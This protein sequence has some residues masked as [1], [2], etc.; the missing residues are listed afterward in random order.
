MISK[1]DV[2]FLQLTGKEKDFSANKI[3]YLGWYGSGASAMLEYAESYLNS[4]GVFIYELAQCQ[5]SVDKYL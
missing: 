5:T 2:L 1:D 3:V 4:A